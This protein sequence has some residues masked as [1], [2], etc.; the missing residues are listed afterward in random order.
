MA[1]ATDQEAVQER[2]WIVGQEDTERCWILDPRDCWVR[3]PHYRGPTQP[4]PE[5]YD[6]DDED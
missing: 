1:I 5:S 6:F 4:H 3:N 2:A